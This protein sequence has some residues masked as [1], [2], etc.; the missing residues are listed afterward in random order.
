M[1]SE[2]YNKSNKIDFILRLTQWHLM[3]FLKRK[4]RP[5]ACGFFVTSHCNFHCEFC[6]IW[7]MKPGFQVSEELAR[8]LIVQL[9]DMGVVYFSFSG[10]EPLLIPYVFDL[11]A[12]AKKEGILYTHLVSNGYLMDKNNAQELSSAEVSEISFSLDA[13]KDIHDRQRGIS[14]AFE[15]V[16]KAIE[17]VKTYAPKTRIILNSILDPHRADNAMASLKEAERLRVKIKFQPLNNH[18]CL[19]GCKEPYL[20]NEALTKNEIKE[21][22]NVIDIIKKSNLLAN[23]PF[24]LE[25]YKTYI[26]NNRRGI[27]QNQKC[28]FGYHHIEIFNN[29]IFPCLEGLDWDKGFFYE[30]TESLKELLSSNAYRRIL[31]TLKK[32]N[33]CSK[34]Y[35]VCYF[36]PRLNFPIWNFV[37]TRLIYKW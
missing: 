14:G 8:K 19:S 29:Q 13:E 35:Y 1:I 32:C 15:G 17:N 34:C 11:L 24:F 25:N 37:R 33:K 36:E 31:L 21:L 23:T 20:G 30:R 22:F 6:N 7:R 12:A 5:L 2:I 10:G 18:P 28:I 26:Q 4:V 27:L 9:A 16:M 3:Y